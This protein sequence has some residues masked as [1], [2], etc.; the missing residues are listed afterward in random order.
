MD[1][2]LP[3]DRMIQ[4][5]FQKNPVPAWLYLALL[6]SLA[7][8]LW[9]GGSWFYKQQK[10]SQEASPFLQVTNRDFSRFLWQF[11]E[12]MRANVSS[13]M[14]YLPGFQY[15]GK[16]N[17]VPGEAEQYVVA[18]PNVLFLYHTWNRLI[19]N[20]FAKRPIPTQDFREFLEAIPEWKP[21]NWPAAPDG[22]RN[23]VTS[24]NGRNERDIPL[25]MIPA[26]V[27]QAFIGWKNFYLEGELINQVKPTF[28]DMDAFLKE[29]P[30]YR[31]NF[32]RNIVKKGKPNYLLKLFQGRFDPKDEIP[33]E[34]L[35]GF[36]KVA[37]FNY[38]QAKKNL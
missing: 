19:S 28:G 22:Y 9:G 23:F 10:S 1:S 6:A 21:E 32:W 4:D 14:G 18:P 16:V 17:I 15:E 20:E 36:L 8:L 13:K 27:Q 24:L 11:P 3:E 29:F 30:H 35:A 34:E 31:R 37:F 33:E 26:V 38:T 7:A 25:Y 2:E 12:Y 5:S